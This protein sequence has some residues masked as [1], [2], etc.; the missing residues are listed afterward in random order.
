MCMRNK[1][2]N[3]RLCRVT[4]SFAFASSFIPLLRLCW[5]VWSRPLMC[6]LN[7]IYNILGDEVKFQ[8]IFFDAYSSIHSISGKWN[9]QTKKL[10]ASKL[11]AELEHQCVASSLCPSLTMARTTDA[12]I[13]L[14]AGRSCLLGGLL[15]PILSP[16]GWD[17]KR[18]KTQSCLSH[19]CWDCSS[20]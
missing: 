6:R 18:P 5:P 11:K 17:A 19:Q 8:P 16:L 9:E 12:N 13:S 20:T 14:A 2:N 1:I 4:T 3:C 15:G 7:N 10:G